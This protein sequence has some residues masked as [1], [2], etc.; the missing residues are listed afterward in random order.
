MTPQEKQQLNELIEWKARKEKQQLSLPLDTA[1][2]QALS[3]A[4]IPSLLSKVYAEYGIFKQLS[5]GSGTTTSLT[6][7]SGAVLVTESVHTIDTEAS[8]STDDLDTLNTAN[9]GDGQIVVLSADSS[10]RTV[11]VKDGTG[12][13]RLNGDFTMDHSRDRIVLIRRINVWYELCRSDN[14]T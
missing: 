3:Q 10:S 14:D 4:L 1:S 9:I 7:E 6:I 8:A 11:V 12:N 13:L 2:I 5:L